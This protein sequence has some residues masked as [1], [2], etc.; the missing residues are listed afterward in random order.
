MNVGLMTLA[1]AVGQPDPHAAPPILPP[2]P[3]LFVSVTAPAGTKVTWQP[4]T[5]EAATTPGPVGLRPGYWHRFQLAGLPGSPETFLYPSVEVR[6]TLIPRP[7]LPDVSRHPVPIAITDADIDAITAGRLVTK[8]YLLE[9]PDRAS[10]IPGAAGEAQEGPAAS[11]EAAIEE[12][13]TRGRPL[14]IFRLGTRT[15]TREEVIAENVPGT[16]LVPWA[17][18]LP[19]PAGRPRFPFGGVMVYDPR[20]GPKGAEEECLKDG[21]DVGAR[22]GVAPDGG[23]GGLDPSDTAMRFTTRRGTVVVPSNRVAICV[24]RFMAVRAEAGPGGVHTLRAPEAHQSLRPVSHLENRMLPA[25]FHSTEKP[26][27]LIGSQR[28]SMLETRT[29]P[30]AVEQWSGRPAGLSSIKGTAVLAQARGPEEITTYRGQALLLEKSVDPAHPERIGEVVTVT[31]RFTNPTTEEMSEILIA[32]SLT[33]RLEYVD[34]SARSSRP[35]TFTTTAN[36]AGSVVLRWALD[37]TL[38]PGESGRITFQV[39]IR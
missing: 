26:A 37:G 23:I 38:K 10:P 27:G 9:D 29:G 31:L 34:G 3:F 16:V 2:A 22:M 24:P 25:E 28:A 33:G 13:R 15:F 36:K 8:V 17:R 14:L 19:M 39:R 11:E 35:A 32:D 20:L 1:L 18:E 6:G 4:G 30:Q 7:G 21:G 5:A 12:A